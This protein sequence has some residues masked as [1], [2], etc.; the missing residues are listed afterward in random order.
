M[1][2]DPALD[3]FREPASDRCWW[4][5]DKA[6]TQEHRIKR[7]TLKRVATT[8]G[9]MDPKNVYKSSSDFRGALHSIDKGSQVRWRKNLCARCNNARSQ[10]FDV[11]YDIFDGFV[12]QGAD[13][14]MKCEYLD[15]SSVFGATWEKQS[16]DLARYFGKQLGCMLASQRLPVPS[17][18]IEFLNGADRCP[19]VWFALMI[20]WRAAD[21]HRIMRRSGLEDGLSSF[22]GLIDSVAYQSDGR[23]SG[24]R[25]AYHIGYVWVMADWR[26]GTD[27]LSWFEN[28]STELILINGTIRDRI[29]WYSRRLVN[30]AR[31][32]MRRS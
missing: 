31:N 21:A 16:A 2:M 22:V 14:L 23:F 7:S 8:D 10:P 17:D 26:V 20:N 29:V 19:S 6:T 27:R 13:S 24:V 5:G 30:D 1:A 18:L 15:W 25:Y 12:V 28:P 3:Q 11:A 9:R 4:C 32:L